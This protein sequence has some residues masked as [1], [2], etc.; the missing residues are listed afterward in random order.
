M[1]P[2]PPADV[3]TAK[4]KKKAKFSAIWAVPVIAA[5][6]AGWLVFISV[7]Q[8]GPADYHCF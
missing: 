4:L 2:K 7:R 8:V 1:N 5:I 6:V 3:P